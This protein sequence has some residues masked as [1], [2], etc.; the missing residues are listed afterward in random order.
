MFDIGMRIVLM[1]TTTAA[2]TLVIA[3][4]VT[5][6]A[7]GFL[8][9]EHGERDAARAARGVSAFF[10]RRVVVSA[11]ATLAGVRGG[12]RIVRAHGRRAVD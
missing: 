2:A 6:T 10:G 7:A 11:P 12:I 9:R 8:R 1:P 4:A 5:S 3:V